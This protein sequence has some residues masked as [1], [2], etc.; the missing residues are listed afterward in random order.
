MGIFK[1]YDIRGLYPEEINGEMAFK[2]G[3]AF[4][5]MIRGKNIVVGSDARP[6]SPELKDAILAGLYEAGKGI[7]DAGLCTTPMFY[8]A[9]NRLEGDAGVMITASHLGP[10]YNGMK[11]VEKG[12]ISLTYESGIGEIEKLV[13]DVVYKKSEYSCSKVDVKNDYLKFIARG[14]ISLGD[15]IAVDTGNGMMGMVV[16]DVLDRIGIEYV[17]IYFDV[18]MSFPNHEANPIKKETLDDLKKVVKKEGAVMG[19]AFDGDGDRLGVLDEKGEF[20][21]GDILIALIAKNILKK[22]KQKILYDLRSSKIVPETI[23]EMGGIPVKSRV[24]HSFI[25]RSMKEEDIFFGGEL[26]GHFY[27]KESFYV[28]S[29]LMAMINL[30]EIIA[31]SGKKM[32]DLVRPLKKYSQSGEI[33]FETS[34]KN[35]K[36]GQ[37]EKIYSAKGAKIEKI[38]G[39]TVEF[40]DWWFNV[41]PSNTEDLLRLNLEA[42]TK[43][44][45]EAKVKEVEGI[46]KGRMQ[47]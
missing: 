5:K 25:S 33:N 15:K 2:I 34:N 10:E 18:D 47:K 37:I 31:S 27:F 19:V 13:K 16:G 17:P 20:V 9:V 45:M 22:G 21:P 41:R 3:Y 23:K 40:G 32:S 43:D 1:T 44:L 6:S 39:I 28:E 42:E 11:L 12:G 7:L 14:K 46:I 26:S 8:F 35:S 38:D 24:G 29:S 4:G 30:L 36:L